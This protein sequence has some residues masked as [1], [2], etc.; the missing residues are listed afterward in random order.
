MVSIRQESLFNIQEWYE[1]VPTQRY[2]EMISAIDLDEIYHNVTKKSRLGAPKKLCSILISKPLI[3]AE[4]GDS[5]GKS[6]ARWDPAGAKR[7]GGSR[8]ARG[9]RPP[10]AEIN[11]QVQRPQIRKF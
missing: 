4:G 8:P 2:Q 10:V 6:V 3:G 11:T 9:K 5:C 7:R 1:M